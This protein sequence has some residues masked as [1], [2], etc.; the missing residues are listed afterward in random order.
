[1]DGGLENVR[2][3]Y[4]L[5]AEQSV[6]GAVLLDSSCLTLIMQHLKPEH[7]YVTPH[8]DIYACMVRM[9]T[10]GQEIDFVTLLEELKSEGVY[11]EA[12]GKNYLLQLAESVPTTQ[13]V[14]AYCKIVQE[15]YYVR[16]LVSV[17]QEIVDNAADE[18][19]DAARLLDSTEQKIFEIRQ[20]R[21]AHGLTRID[22]II[23]D[24]YD[25]LQK[26]TGEDKADFAGLS[27]GF[28]EI[29][30]IT[31]GLNKS[32]LI[33][34]AARPAM[35]KTSFAI[36]IAEYV[37]AKSDKSVAIFSLEMSKEQLVSR[38]LSSDA[39]IQSHLLRSGNLTGDDWVKLA[40]AAELL[41]KSPIYIDDSAGITVP[42]MKARL[43]RVKNLGL[44]VID[45][46]QLM[47]T[48]K[49]ISNRVQEVSEITRNLKIMAK[50]LQVPVI[51]LSQ[52][53]RSTEGRAD[54]RPMLSDL[55]ESG[56]I[57]QDADIVMFLYRDEYYNQESS[58][59]NIAECIL[60]KNRHGAVGSIKLHWQGEYTKFSN[61]EM[62]RHEG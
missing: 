11:D 49:N 22:E 18:S 53:S 32:D 19:V 10:T 37:A 34:I 20:G 15:K 54:H 58:E 44:V 31:T 50:D 21:N 41:S 55:R 24:T 8:R 4:S 6:L 51:T 23:I 16:T 35:G 2:V 25:Q 17:A 48:G 42:E 29:D 27:T 60:A 52:L 28:S 12:G 13:N 59:H 9:F 33:L 47:S 40:E 36:N 39:L 14:E 38:M 62:G 61:L 3:P 45:Y 26:L 1:M 46:L 43:R 30:R 57:E 5:E 56:S 7:F